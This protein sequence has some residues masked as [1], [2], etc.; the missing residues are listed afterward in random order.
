MANPTERKGEPRRVLQPQSEWETRNGRVTE[1]PW[2]IKHG[3]RYYL[4]Y[5]GSGAN[6]PDYAVGYAVADHPLGPFTRA[7]HNPIIERSEGLFGPG[8]GCAI[9]DDAG[10]WWHIYHQKNTARVEWSRFI[11]MDPLWFDA[12][13]RLH[14]KAT[15]GVEQEGPT[16]TDP[17]ATDVPPSGY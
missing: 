14:G 7:A 13:G 9:Q 1:G 3:G 12:A 11:A 6:T 2:M 17:N 16:G 8:H 15:R 4:L 10:R 5:S